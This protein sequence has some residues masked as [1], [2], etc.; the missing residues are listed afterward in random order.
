[1][2]DAVGIVGRIGV[3]CA[4]V[5]LSGCQTTQVN[6]VPVTPEEFGQWAGDAVFFADKCG[7]DTKGI[8]DRIK[9]SAQNAASRSKWPEGDVYGW[10][11]IRYASNEMRL[12]KMVCPQSGL[13]GIQR[14]WNQLLLE[15]R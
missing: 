8:D 13:D 7:I 14:N 1:M 11:T 15:L 6:G 3:A 12:R 5:V 10:Y 4:V 9:R 2:G